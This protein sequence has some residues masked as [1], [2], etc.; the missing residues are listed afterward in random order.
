MIRAFTE[1]TTDLK[2]CGINPGL[3]FMYNKAP[4]ALEIEMTNMDIKYQLVPPISH[5]ANNSDR[6]IQMFKNIS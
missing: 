1:F 4:T 5:R 6:A 3:H 2:I